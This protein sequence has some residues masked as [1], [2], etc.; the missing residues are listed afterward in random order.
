MGLSSIE[1]HNRSVGTILLHITAS[2]CMNNGY[3]DEIPKI[4]TL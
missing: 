1:A 3:D 2:M 4:I